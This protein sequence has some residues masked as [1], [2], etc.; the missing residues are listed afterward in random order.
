MF[1]PKMP[2]NLPRKKDHFLSG[3]YITSDSEWRALLDLAKQ[4]DPDAE[5]G[6]ADR[7][8]DGCKDTTGKIVVKRSPRKAAVWFQRSAEHGCAPAQNGFGA[9]LSRGQ[10]IEKDVKKALFWFKKALHDESLRSMVAS[11]IAI[12]YREN[13]NLRAAFRWFQKSADLGDDDALVQVG[14]HYYWGKGVKKNPTAAI[15]CFR[16]ATKGNNICEF[17]RDDAFFFLGVANFEGQGVK[18]SIPTAKRSFERAN[19]DND[20]PAAQKM[21]RMINQ[22]KL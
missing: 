5:W 20:H 19:K 17:G 3:S 18:K 6:V 16:A 12:T 1:N 13:G 10:G 11:N 21:L 22:A 15:R 2:W 7:Y 9:L 4:G 8:G 14:I